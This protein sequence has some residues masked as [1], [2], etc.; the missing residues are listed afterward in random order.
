M[1]RARHSVAA[2]RLAFA[3]HGTAVRNAEVEPLLRHADAATLVRTVDRLAGDGRR[4]VTIADVERE[5]AG[6]SLFGRGRA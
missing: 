3:R 6:A 4:D 1:S 5:I 2:V